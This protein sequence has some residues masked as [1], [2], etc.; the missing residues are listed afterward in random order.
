M[1]GGAVGVSLRVFVGLGRDAERRVASRRGDGPVGGPLLRGR[2]RPRGGP[3]VAGGTPDGVGGLPLRRGSGHSG[4]PRRRDD[5]RG[6]FLPHRALPPPGLGRGHR[7]RFRAVPGHRRRRQKRGLQNRPPPPPLSHLSL[8]LV[9]LHLRPHRR[10]VRTL[11]RR[12]PPRLRTGHRPLRLRRRSR[13][14]RPAI[15]RRRRRRRRRC[16]RRA[17]SLV[18]LRRLPRRR[19][20]PRR[21][22]HRHRLRGPQGSR[23][24]LPERQIA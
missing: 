9:Q 12:D 10:R 17:F 23:R 5:R 22:G 6:N 1:V 15:R 8:R 16:W 18:R 3:G 7:R 4:G 19:H 2:L 24:G 21:K 11:P 13:L 20:R 14:G